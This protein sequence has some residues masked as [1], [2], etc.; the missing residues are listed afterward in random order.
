MGYE[1]MKSKKKKTK[2]IQLPSQQLFSVYKD[3]K[4]EFSY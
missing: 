1:M 4:I 2:N 3:W